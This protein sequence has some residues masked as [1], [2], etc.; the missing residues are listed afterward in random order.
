MVY[1]WT[2]QFLPQD[3]TPNVLVAPLW[4][5]GHSLANNSGVSVAT[6]GTDYTIVE[7]DD[8]RSYSFYNSNPNATDILDYQ[9]IF[10]TRRVIFLHMT[11][12]TTR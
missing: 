2:N 11:M 9:V 8:M 6:Y 4:R 5:D 3:I 10:Q 1:T 7:W 12:G